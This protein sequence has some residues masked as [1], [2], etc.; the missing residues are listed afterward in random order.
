MGHAFVQGPAQTEPAGVVPTGVPDG[1]ELPARGRAHKSFKAARAT[2]TWLDGQKKFEHLE[3]S[4]VT[5]SDGT[6]RVIR[7]AREIP[8]GS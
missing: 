3:F 5:L 7:R 2:A 4:A 1:W 6:H 8:V